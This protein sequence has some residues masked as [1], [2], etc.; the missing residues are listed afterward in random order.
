MEHTSFTHPTD[1]CP[2]CAEPR[3]FDCDVLCSCELEAINIAL[4]DVDFGA[5]DALVADMRRAEIAA[6]AD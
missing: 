3:C 6:Y 2:D 5:L 1:I 4:E